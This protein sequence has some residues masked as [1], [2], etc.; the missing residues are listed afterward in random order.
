MSPHYEKYF[1]VQSGF[2]RRSVNERDKTIARNPTGF[3][4][5]NINLSDKI[6]FGTQSAGDRQNSFRVFFK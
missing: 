3:L 6:T 5:H 4:S 1:N 2:L